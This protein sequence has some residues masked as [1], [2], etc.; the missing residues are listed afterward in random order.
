MTPYDTEG[1]TPTFCPCFQIV[2]ILCNTLNKY[3]SSFSHVPQTLP[4]PEDVAVNKTDYI[5]AQMQL[6]FPWGVEVQTIKKAREYAIWQMV[7]TARKSFKYGDKTRKTSP[8]DDILAK[9]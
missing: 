3:L 8:K 6:I 4:D 2:C 9:T 1:H 7:E 5:L